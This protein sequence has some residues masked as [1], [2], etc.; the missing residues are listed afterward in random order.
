MK[1]AVTG[2]T[3]AIGSDLV[4]LALDRGYEVVAI[5]RPNS[6]N[7]SNLPDSDRLKTVFSDVSDYPAVSADEHCDVFYHLA[8]METFGEKRDDVYTQCDNIRYSLDAVHLADRWGAKAFVGAG[9]QAEYGPQSMR[10]GANTPVNPESGY[11]MAKYAAGKLCGLLCSQLGIR[12]NWVRI[13]SVYGEHDSERTLP[14][15]VINSLLSGKP[16]ELTNCD[17]IWDYIYSRDAAAALVAIGEHGADGKSYALSSGK[18]RRLKDYVLSIR[19]AVD[20]AIEPIFGAKPYYPH[21]PMMLCGD[22]SEL[23]EDTGFVPEFEF[24]EGIRNVVD[25]VRKRNISNKKSD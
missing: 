11:G 7:L 19:D 10:L 22:I 15:Y 2:P 16:P 9:S 4:R 21:Q 1:I 25:S 24:E 12:F 20:P 3:G 18:A 5:V 6:R 13:L 23:T 17:Q 14:M 8:W